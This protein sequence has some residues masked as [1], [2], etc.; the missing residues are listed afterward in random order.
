M[1]RLITVALLVASLAFPALGQE[2]NS[3]MFRAPS[4]LL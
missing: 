1:K 4:P 2:M 3:L